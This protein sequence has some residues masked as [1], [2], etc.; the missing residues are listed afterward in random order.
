[1]KGVTDRTRQEGYD[2]A[3]SEL[4][5][6]LPNG[7]DLGSVAVN[8]WKNSA[9]HRAV[10]LGPRFTEAGVGVAKSKAGRGC[11]CQVGRAAVSALEDTLLTCSIENR[12]SVVVRFEAGG[13]G[14][15]IPLK[16]GETFEIRVGTEEG[17]KREAGARATFIP[18]GGKSVSAMVHHR[19]RY[20]ITGDAKG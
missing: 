7:P 3:V 13:T 11:F 19:G 12:A 15:A 2:G 20:R 5:H 8:F 10:L 9:P 17:K 14:K 6:R 1:G 4:L 16:P 18:E